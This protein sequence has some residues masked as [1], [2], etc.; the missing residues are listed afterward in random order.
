MYLGKQVIVTDIFADPL[1]ED[2]RD[3]AAASGLR[4]CW[5]T[6]ILSGTGN[7]L[8]SFA[9]YYREPQVPSGAEAKLTE[10]A[11]HIAGIAIEHQ[12]AEESLRA[13]EKRFAKTFHANPHPM[14][15]ATL[16]EGRIIDVNESFVELTGYERAELIGSTLRDR[17]WDIPLARDEMVQRVKDQGAIRNVEVRLRTKS[18]VSRVVLLSSELVDIDGRPCLLSASNDI[19]AR[20][21]AEDQLTLLQAITMDVAAA[22]DLSS[23]LEVVLRRVCEKTG[24]VLGQAW[25]P[26]QDASVLQCSPA[27]FTTTDGLEE[28]RIGSEDCKL[29]PGV[30][31]PGRVW[32]SKQPAWIRDVTLDTNFPRARFAEEVGLKAALGIPI[33]SGDQVIAVIEFFLREPQDEDERLVK[34]ITSVAA[35]LD[36]VIER[37]HAEDELRRTQGELAHVSR[38]TMMGELAASIAH[39]VNQP[40]GAIVGN[41]DVCL[42]W[43]AAGQPDLAM[44]QEALE[45]ISSDGRRASEVISR[46]RGLVKKSVPQKVTLDINDV[47]RETQALVDHEAQRK[48]IALKAELARELPAVSGDRVQLQQVLLNL[49]M[50]G[51]DAMAGIERQKRELFLSTAPDG[52]QTLVIVRD[53]GVGI[54]PKETDRVFKAFHTTKSSGMG[55]GLPISRSI[56]EAHGGRL[57]V[58]PNEGPGVS[59]KFTLPGMDK[60]AHD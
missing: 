13:S 23:A 18:G 5:S 56:V 47:V 25:V 40:L 16:E 30:G 57:W 19:T 15:L 43:L 36:M 26:A 8:G 50:N 51:M 20:R 38:V 33:L 2:Y 54:D 29:A 59:F 32:S 31:L 24:W 37:K 45:D 14:S 28:F 53:C 1:W 35:Q 52:D 6:P 44:L 17:S 60:T 3:L 49:L 58:E 48:G 41:A 34:V 55:M 27:W 11:T 7:V 10:V 46:I 42:R 39:E 9:M 12:R 22:E 4:A 21:R